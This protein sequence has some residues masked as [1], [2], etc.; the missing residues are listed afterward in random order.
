MYIMILYP[1]IMPN[2]IQLIL[3]VLDVCFLSNMCDLLRE[4]NYFPQV[5]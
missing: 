2:I 4:M 5:R 3:V 1:V